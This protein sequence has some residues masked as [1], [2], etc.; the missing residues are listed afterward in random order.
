MKMKLEESEERR[1]KEKDR[2]AHQVEEMGQ[3]LRLLE[4]QN[5]ELT[6][7]LKEFENT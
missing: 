1:N 5:I 6:G 2:H 4:S 7:R 3:R